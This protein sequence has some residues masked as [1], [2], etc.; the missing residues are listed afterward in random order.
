MIPTI[1]G[2]LAAAFA[3]SA[4][5]TTLGLPLAQVL[6]PTGVAPVGM[7]ATLGW[8]A[9][10]AVSLPI[11]GVIGFGRLHVA[12]LAASG[13]AASLTV[14]ARTG[15]GARLLPSKLPLS[16][17]PSWALPLASA[18][19]LLP[20]MAVLPKLSADGLA[21]SPP[22]FDHV[23]IAIVDG[24]V[25]SGLPVRNPFLEGAGSPLAYYYL[26]HFSAAEV[27]SILGSGGWAADA[28]MTGV[29]AFSSLALAMAVAQAIGGRKL[30]CAAVVLVS[31]AG[32]LR[33]LLD[34][35]LG[36]P[37]SRAFVRGDAELGGW[38]NQA[39]WVPQ[40][41]ASAC[42][43][44]AAVLA[45]LR[46]AQGGGTLAIPL[47]GIVSAAGFES[48]TWVGGVTFAAAAPA[49]ALVLIRPM[50]PPRWR[51]AARLAASAL[52]TVGF[53]LPFMLGQ[54]GAGGRP[55][56]GHA[57]RSGAL[58]GAGWVGA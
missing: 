32:T 30:A 10:S 55:G 27:A 41:L 5:F 12:M 58:P 22:I 31:L 11:L 44:V 33:P 51:Y 35:V 9:F 47:L 38:L 46:M 4:F 15:R 17:L 7:A 18:A 21:L 45:M 52:V 40:H 42:C 23:K 24:I 39:A 53:A 34:R 19:A 3:V 43:V 37:L 25:R 56:G 6:A 29:T 54:F 28:A 20:M 36:Q 16:T 14:L 2:T 1:I 48:S 13:L 57:Y 49:A 8:A 50:P 26:W